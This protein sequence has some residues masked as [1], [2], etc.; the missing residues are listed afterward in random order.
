MKAVLSDIHANL[1]AL[2]AVLADARSLGISEFI[3]L[4]DVIG[5]GPN[6]REC[7]DVV[8]AF[9]VVLLGNHDHAVCDSKLLAQLA[10]S[11]TKRSLLRT[12]EQLTRDSTDRLGYLRKLPKT[13]E[14]GDFL[15]VHGSPRDPVHEYVFPEDVYDTRKLRDIFSSFAQY[16]LTGHTHVPGVFTDD[17]QFLR[18]AEIGNAW[19]LTGKRTLINVGSVG[20]P[21]HGD[22]RACYVVLDHSTVSFR[23]VAYDFDSTIRKIRD[24]PPNPDVS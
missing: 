6:P 4:G 21:R 2:N 5:Y 10:H 24:M 13:Y 3:C 11:T 1:E 23:F 7:V 22:N 19:E 20:Q 15:F 9:D 8:S 14:D 17:F 18:P 16:C 12:R